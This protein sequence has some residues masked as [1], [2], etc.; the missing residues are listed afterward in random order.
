MA[1]PS[2]LLRVAGVVSPSG[3]DS[4]KLR[5]FTEHTLLCKFWRVQ[6]QS[7]LKNVSKVFILLAPRGTFWPVIS[8]AL[9]SKGRNTASREGAERRGMRSLPQGEDPRFRK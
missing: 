8:T 3:C 6:S 5:S 1:L 7:R 4:A 2:E 9:G